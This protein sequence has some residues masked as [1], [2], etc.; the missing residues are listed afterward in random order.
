MTSASQSGGN[1][2]RSIY[3]VGNGAKFLACTFSPIFGMI[4]L[5]YIFREPRE[6]KDILL[7]WRV[8]LF[9]G[10]VAFVGLGL[11]LW[12]V[13]LMFWF[14]LRSFV[15]PKVTKGIFCGTSV[16]ETR[17]GR[18]S[19]MDIAIGDEKLRAH[20]IPEL[21]RVLATVPHGSQVR[22]TSGPYNAIVR[23]EVAL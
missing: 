8:S 2:F 9:G 21:I 1:G 19:I 23:V 18:S 6:V 7:F 22:V 3:Y 11:I 13:T 20:T 5:S 15:F 16:H 4:L 12:T 14:P 10:L 17:K